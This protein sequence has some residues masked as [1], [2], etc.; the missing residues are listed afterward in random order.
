MQKAAIAFMLL[1][2]AL[3]I[4]C[5]T[6]PD[7][8][9]RTVFAVLWVFGPPANLVYGTGYM[10]PFIV[11]TLIVVFMFYRMLRA[12]AVVA[13]IALIAGLVMAWSLF[14]ALAYAPAA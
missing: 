4:T 10:V 11:G 13:R 3:S 2:V 7:S 8:A 14:G 9:V 12:A 5:A 1:Y 6:M